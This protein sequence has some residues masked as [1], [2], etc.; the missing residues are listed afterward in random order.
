MFDKGPKLIQ[1]IVMGGRKTLAIDS[2]CLVN[3]IIVSIVSLGTIMEL[4]RQVRV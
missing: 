1:C 3:L 2:Q 4:D